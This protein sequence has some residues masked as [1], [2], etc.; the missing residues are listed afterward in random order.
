[1]ILS[2]AVLE[3]ISTL[4]SPIRDQD[5][6]IK[7]R[8]FL[9]TLWKLFHDNYGAYLTVCMILKHELCDICIIIYDFYELLYITENR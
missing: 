8:P 9:E 1:M 2:Y 3:K 4:Y 6:H 7:F 5:S